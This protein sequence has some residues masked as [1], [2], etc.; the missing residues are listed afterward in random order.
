MPVPR[1]A[2]IINGIDP[3]GISSD[4]IFLMKSK[5]P[6]ND[7]TYS[8][9]GTPPIMIINKITKNVIKAKMDLFM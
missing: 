7:Q 4:G 5:L 2:T 6:G 3:R 8:K 9:T 1:R